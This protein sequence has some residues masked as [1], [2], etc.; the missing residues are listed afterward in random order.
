MKIIIELEEIQSGE[1][2]PPVAF[3]SLH[4]SKPKQILNADTVGKTPREFSK[5]RKFYKIKDN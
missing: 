3:H 1:K 2:I 5:D 4:G